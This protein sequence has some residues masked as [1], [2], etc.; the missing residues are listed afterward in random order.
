MTEIW[1]LCDF[2]VPPLPEFETGRRFQRINPSVQAV[3]LI[4]V[5]L[6]PRWFNGWI[7]K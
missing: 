7:I 6:F 2:F 1:W 4:K 3:G 5:G